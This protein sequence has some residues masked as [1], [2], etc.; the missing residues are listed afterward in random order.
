[1]NSFGDAENGFS[2]GYEASTKTVRISGWGF[3]DASL[4]AVFS[5]QVLSVCLAAERPFE[6]VFDAIRLKPQGGIAQRSL[7]TMMAGVHAL[8]PSRFSLVVGS[9]L[10]RL[11]L[12]RLARENGVSHWDYT[13]ADTRGK[14]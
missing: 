14:R 9:A 10:T 12:A 4:S 6:V 11:Q 3:W 8:S 1:M 2:V 13:A 5:T 7:G